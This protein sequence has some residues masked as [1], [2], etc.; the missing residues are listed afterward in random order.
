MIGV[1]GVAFA[2]GDQVPLAEPDH[3]TSVSLADPNGEDFGGDPGCSTLLQDLPTAEESASR[4]WGSGM[5]LQGPRLD[6][7]VVLCG[8][9]G[10]SSSKGGVGSFNNAKEEFG[11]A[12]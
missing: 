8:V 4:D 3:V 6:Q 9:G 10:R 1:V 2:V 7:D 5:F 11:K 12:I